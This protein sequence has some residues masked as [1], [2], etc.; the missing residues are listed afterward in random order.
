MEQFWTS[1][2]FR[3]AI[4][5]DV[6]QRPLAWEPLVA[7]LPSMH[8]VSHPFIEWCSRPKDFHHKLRPE[9]LIQCIWP[10]SGWTPSYL[11]SDSLQ[12]HQVGGDHNPSIVRPVSCALSGFYVPL[13]DSFHSHV[14][15]ILLNWSEGLVPL[16]L[17][18]WA[19]WVSPEP[20]QKDCS[21]TQLTHIMPQSIIIGGTVITKCN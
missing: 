17:T 15:P 4:K 14:L 3:L 10:L 1:W 21:D 20:L 6:M 18:I 7:L 12:Q 8:L 9:P 13:V 2:L 16:F 19:T 5:C 11:T